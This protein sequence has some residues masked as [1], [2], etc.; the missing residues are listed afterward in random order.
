MPALA[1]I[2]LNTQRLIH[3]EHKLVYIQTHIYA[4]ISFACISYSRISGYLATHAYINIH[5]TYNTY[6]F[7]H[8]CLD[9]TYLPVSTNTYLHSCQLI[10]MYLFVHNHRPASIHTFAH[11]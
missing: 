8:T 4:Y 1:N 9:I 2:S 5:A 11:P 6:K 7:I 3:T 10:L